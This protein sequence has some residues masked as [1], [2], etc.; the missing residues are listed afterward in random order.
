[1]PLVPLV[2]RRLRRT[3]STHHLLAGLLLYAPLDRVDDLGRKGFRGGGIDR[4]DLFGIEFVLAVG[5]QQAVGFLRGIG[6]LGIAEAFDRRAVE[7]RADIFG[8]ARQVLLGVGDGVVTVPAFA[9]C[10]GVGDPANLGRR[11]G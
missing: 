8:V 5:G 4:A 1:M 11:T 3:P 2:Y 9:A 6:E 10:R 7:D